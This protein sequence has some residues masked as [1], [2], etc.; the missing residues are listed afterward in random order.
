MKVS[1]RIAPIIFLLIP[2]SGLAKEAPAPVITVPLAKSLQKTVNIGHGLMLS[3]NGD[4][5]DMQIK[6]TP[7]GSTGYPWHC[8]DNLVYWTFHGPDK[9]DIMPWQIKRK[10]FSNTRIIPVCG[11]PLQLVVHILHPKI[12][13]VKGQS[14]FTA[15][16]LTIAVEPGE[17]Q[18]L[19]SLYTR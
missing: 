1:V 4:G 10:F 2:A 16:T 5:V 15:G 9:S 6:V 11:F 7:N 8:F 18:D 3:V 14:M 12:R 19:G 13:S 17:K